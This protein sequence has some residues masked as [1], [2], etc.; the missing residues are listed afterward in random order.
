MCVHAIVCMIASQ[1]NVYM[2]ACMQVCALQVAEGLGARVCAY[3][4]AC[5]NVCAFKRVC[6]LWQF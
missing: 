5:E 3:A 4:C 1:M 6:V 2:L